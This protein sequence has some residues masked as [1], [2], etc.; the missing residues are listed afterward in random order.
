MR[1]FTTPLL[2]PFARQIRAYGGEIWHL[3][4]YDYG[5][6]IRANVNGK[7]IR[8]VFPPI[9]GR[10]AR[11]P[12]EPNSLLHISKAQSLSDFKNFLSQLI[13]KAG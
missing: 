3:D 9:T 10:T 6:L 5:F 11:I 4:K 12:D 7:N 2:T 13:C 1:Q 8:V